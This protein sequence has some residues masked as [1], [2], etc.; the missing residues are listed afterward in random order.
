MN[1]RKRTETKTCEKTGSSTEKTSYTLGA[2][3]PTEFE[4]I[5]AALEL[6]KDQDTETG[7]EAARMLEKMKDV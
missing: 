7:K 5:C 6:L 1:L 4:T 2:L 3:T